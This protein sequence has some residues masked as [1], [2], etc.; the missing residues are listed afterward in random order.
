MLSALSIRTASSPVTVTC[1]CM[2]AISVPPAPAVVTS[3][4]V[5]DACCASV[6][7]KHAVA[8]WLATKPYGSSTG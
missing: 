2:T 3:V 1:T 6:A 8:R 7:E 5:T 4:I